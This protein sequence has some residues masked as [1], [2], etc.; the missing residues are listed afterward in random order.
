MQQNT[1]WTVKWLRPDRRFVAFRCTACD[2]VARGASA[3]A[4]YEIIPRIS[5][6]FLMP[7]GVLGFP[8]RVLP[9]RRGLADLR[10]P[11]QG[12]TPPG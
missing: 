5:L 8:N 12:L 4:C 7:A 6:P 11:Y 9:P 1:Y 2:F 10:D 3:F